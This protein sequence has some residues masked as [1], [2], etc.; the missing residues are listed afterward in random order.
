MVLRKSTLIGLSIL[1]LAVVAGT[2]LAYLRCRRSPALEAWIDYP[3][4][5]MSQSAKQQFLEGSF[6]TIKKVRNLPAPVLRAFTEKGGSRLVMADAGKAFQATDVIY[7]DLPYK[8]LIFAGV[9]SEKCFVHYEQ[10]GRAH[11]YRLAL[12]TL[13]SK[14]S[15]KPI[16]L[17]HCKGRAA[18]LEDLRSWLADGS[19]S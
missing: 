19:C 2:S 14:D 11:L 3:S 17:G 4:E 16:W 1:G 10:G 5:K 6:S 15:M 9:S 12:F 18:R 7:F 8:R 13:T